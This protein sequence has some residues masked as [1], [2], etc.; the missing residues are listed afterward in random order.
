MDTVLLTAIVVLGFVWIPFLWSTWTLAKE[1]EA[2]PS[3]GEEEAK[4]AE[5]AKTEEEAVKQEA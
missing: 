5:E 2:L 4:K 3:T 1:E